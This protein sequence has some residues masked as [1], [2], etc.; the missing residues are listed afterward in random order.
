MQSQQPKMFRNE[1]G[2]KSHSFQQKIK[3]LSE[4]VKTI[5]HR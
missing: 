2:K 1:A 5:V 4:I 3:L